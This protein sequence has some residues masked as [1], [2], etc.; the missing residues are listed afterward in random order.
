MNGPAIAEP[1]ERWTQ[2]HEGLTIEKEDD[3]P[4]EKDGKLTSAINGRD[5]RT[6]FT[7]RNG[8]YRQTLKQQSEQGTVSVE[9]WLV[10]EYGQAVNFI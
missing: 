1:H 9:L 2:V 5:Q 8:S 7:I 3:D 10:A 6:T 4:A